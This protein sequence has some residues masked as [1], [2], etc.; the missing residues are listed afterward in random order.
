M[1][2]ACA[3][4]RSLLAAA[5][6]ELATATAR[7]DAEVLLADCLARPRSYLYAWPERAIAAR[8]R[9]QFLRRVRRRAA[10]E[11]VAYLTG[12]REFWSLSLAV[13]PD[14]L[15]P[16]PETEILVA[17]TLEKMAPDKALRVAD[18][19]TG[20]G[21]IA[22]AIAGERPHCRV[23][24]SDISPAALAVARGNAGR[25]GIGNVQ[26][27]AGAWC[28]A[29]AA[30]RFDLIV[31]NPPYVAEDDP[32]LQQG[33]VRYEPRHALVSGPGGLDDLERIIGCARN[34]LRAN[35]W[36]IVEHGYDQDMPVRQLF[37]AA[38]YRDIDNHADT[39]GCSRV[40]LGRL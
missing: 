8:Q 18:L 24:A 1:T 13:T 5:T 14:T 35:G 16:R 31:S 29:L 28:A 30:E 11:P 22:L 2:T 15:I 37:T 19:G 4:I 7:L 6:R 26:F 20:C 36:L 23:L 21:A 32:H 10:G 17:L 9:E 39:A 3:S 12:R 38:G 27:V 40:T 34:H 25:C 33:D